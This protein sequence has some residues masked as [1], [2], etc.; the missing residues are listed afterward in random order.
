MNKIIKEIILED[1]SYYT[2]L[3][4]TSGFVISIFYNHELINPGQAIILKKRIDK[5]ND[6]FVKWECRCISHNDSRLVLV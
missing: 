2:F 1:D 5:E 4:L 3:L 6:E